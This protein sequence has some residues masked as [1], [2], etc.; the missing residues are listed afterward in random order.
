MVCFNVCLAQIS[1]LYSTRKTEKN[2]EVSENFVSDISDIMIAVS[3]DGLR[4]RIVSV[5]GGCDRW[6]SI[7]NGGGGRYRGDRRGGA[8]MHDGGGKFGQAE[9]DGNGGIDLIHQIFVE[10]SHFFLE[11]LFIQ[12]TDLLQQD[13]RILGESCTLGVDVDMRGELGLTHSGCNRRCN[14]GRAVA[15]ADVVLY[16]QYGA[17][18]PL[19]GADDGAEVGVID[20]SSFYTHFDPSFLS[21]SDAARGGGNVSVSILSTV[22][23][24]QSLFGVEIADSAR[25]AARCAARWARLY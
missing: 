8:G 11:A 10:M 24:S 25:L 4:R 17:K 16:D 20:I 2:Q 14:D 12:C 9:A 6:G 15:V 19:L 1:P 3:T 13:D 5:R 21:V 22:G 23:W 7:G 18:S